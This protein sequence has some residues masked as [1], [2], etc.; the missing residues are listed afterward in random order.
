MCRIAGIID[1]SSTNLIGE[2]TAMRDCMKHGGPDAEG[3]YLDNEFPLALGHRRLSFLDL[4][5]A[6]NQPMSDCDNQLQ[7]VFN[8]EIYNFK[9][10]KSELQL[11]G[12]Y[13]KTG[14]DTEVILKAY[15]H[16][17]KQC[18]QKFNGM[19]AIA[20]FD[21]RSSQ[22]I[23]ARDHAG[24][25]PLYYSKLANRFYFASEVKAFK[26][27]HSQWQENETW[28]IY[29]L[30]FG[31]IPQPATTLTNVFALKK[32]TLMVVDVTSLSITEETFCA[33]TFQSVITSLT[34]AVSVV[35]QQVES[36]VERHLIA[37]AP[38]GLFLSGGLDSSLLTLLAHRTL[39]QNL[40]TISIT[41]NEE[42]FSEARYQ[43]LVIDKTGANHSSCLVTDHEFFSSLPDIMQAMD[44]PSIDGINSYFICK[45]ARKSGLKAV[46][47]G[48]GAD[49]LFGG[50]DSFNRT[51]KINLLRRIPNFAF[52]LAENMPDSKK[53]KLAFLRRKDLL[54][55]YLLHRGLNTPHQVAAILNCSIKQVNQAID[56]V[57]VP[58]SHEIKDGRDQVSWLDQNL[59]MQNQLLK[60]TDY[61]SMWFGLE[62]RVPFLDK[63]LMQAVHSIAPGIK[64]HSAIKKHLLVKAFADVLPNEISYRRKQGFIFPFKNW[65]TSVQT[66]DQRNPAFLK[67][68]RNLQT[69]SIQWAHYWAYL[70]ACHR[71][72]I[73][74]YPHSPRRVLFLNLKTFSLTGGIEKFNRAFL[75][76]LADHENEGI[77]VADAMSAY[78]SGTDDRYFRAEHY[79][80]FNG[81]VIRF[82]YRVIKSAKQYNTIVLAHI[83]LG[84]I[85]LIIKKVAPKTQIVLITHGIEV[86]ER[87]TASR[88]R[89]VKDADLILAVSRFTKETIQKIHNIAPEKIII[90]PN[91]IDPYFAAPVLFNKPGYLADR[92]GILPQ[93]PVIFTLTR[94]SHDEK[95]KGYDKVMEI[96]PSLKERFPNVRYILSGKHDAEEKSRLEVLRQKNNLEKN[97]IL[98]GFVKEEEIIDHFLLAD[99]FIMPSRAE[100]FGIVFIE[101][102]ACGLSVIAGNKDGSVDALR[103]GELGSLVDPADEAEILETLQT[104]L[105]KKSEDSNTEKKKALQQKVYQSFGFDMY[106]KNLQKILAQ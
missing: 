58:Q 13:F 92:Y 88:R 95:Y 1:P 98:T 51:D 62:V 106:K 83:N 78:D 52:G 19:F 89:T 38:I 18:F 85:G 55:G 39:N 81:S 65:I 16:W 53:R 75:K 104:I 64:Y 34:E 96:M 26:A 35:K 33:F 97:L 79:T 105:H 56:Q 57:S 25:K 46:L 21:K 101:A 43:K 8:G 32:G 70:L 54:G 36:A 41:F 2:I 29:L 45:Y 23:L 84:F 42:Q 15:Q 28:K 87:L 31:H 61:M 11:K 67:A 94:L 12:F 3:V 60:D 24:I 100:G 66:S 10:L 93:T 44:Q 73:R 48:I 17:G 82:V 99:A 49:E 30:T 22:L 6:A 71:S 40:H 47:S 74:Y 9:D 102:M 68:Q 86:S 91:T 20:I 59:Y 27:L 77:V 76:A 37:D 80:A 63:E 7:I 50:Y 72:N 69:G 14:S 5:A 4:S 90:F 103:N